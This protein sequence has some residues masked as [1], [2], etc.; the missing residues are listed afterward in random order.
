MTWSFEARIR[1]A[2]EL[3]QKIPA[4]RELLDFYGH[5]AA[6][7]KSI[8]ESVRSEGQ[9][10]VQQLAVYFPELIALSA[11]AAPQPLA[12]Q[13]SERLQNLTGAGELLRSAWEDGAQH[14]LAADP[15]DRFF[16]LAVLQ[17]YAEYLA[18]RGDVGAEPESQLC[19]FCSSRPVAAVLHP[20]GQGGKRWFLCARCSTEWPFRRVLCGNC[21]EENKDRLPVYTAGQFEAVRVEACDQCHVYIKVVDLT[22]DGNAVPV[23]D[24]LASIALDIWAQEQGYSKLE[25]NLL[26]M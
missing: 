7:Q 16:A 17:P 18:S 11:R 8:F 1:R 3:S 22:S 12:A 9:T 20:E 15:Y 21:G 25:P 2:G 5:V 26:G 6:F 13:A 14:G 24:E 23:V 10:D 19:P 4:A